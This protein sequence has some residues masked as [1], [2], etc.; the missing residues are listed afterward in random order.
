MGPD[1]LFFSLRE[2]GTPLDEL[3]NFIFKVYDALEPFIEFYEE[4]IEP[5]VEDIEN[6]ITPIADFLTGGLYTQ[7]KDTAELMSSTALTAVGAMI[8]RSLILL[9]RDDTGAPCRS[10]R[11]VRRRKTWSG[12][13]R[14]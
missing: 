2:H 12:R 9:A 11:S 4:N 10:A 14:V 7:I 6:G 13:A 3:A 1:Y 5:V 8:T